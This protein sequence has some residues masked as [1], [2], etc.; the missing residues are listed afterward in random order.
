MPDEKYVIISLGLELLVIEIMG[1]I[2]SNWRISDVA[3][4]PSSLGM[5]MSYEARGKE[6]QKKNPYQHTIKEGAY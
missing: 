1:V 3:D 2:G 4:T 6:W 5:T